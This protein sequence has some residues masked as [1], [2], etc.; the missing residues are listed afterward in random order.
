MY[1]HT[2]IY[3]HTSIFCDMSILQM[4][5]RV[6]SWRSNR[7]PKFYM[8]KPSSCFSPTPHLNLFLLQPSPS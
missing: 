3:I 5:F 7:Y 2:Y 6:F 4:L 1:V 8:S